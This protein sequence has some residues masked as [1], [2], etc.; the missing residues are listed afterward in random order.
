M[1]G[2]GFHHPITFWVPTVINAN[3]WVPAILSISRTGVVTLEAP[4]TFT[5][6][7]ANVKLSCLIVETPQ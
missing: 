1:A 2:Y 5:G 4:V 7:S 3:N 6:L